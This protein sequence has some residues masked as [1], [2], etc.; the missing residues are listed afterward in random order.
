MTGRV[1]LQGLADF[2]TSLISRLNTLLAELGE[3]LD[4]AA[5]VL[6]RQDGEHA[7]QVIADAFVTGTGILTLR[8]DSRGVA[9][10]DPAGVTLSFTLTTTEV[11]VAGRDLR[12]GD[13]LAGGQVSDGAGLEVYKVLTPENPDDE[14]LTLLLADG[15]P[16]IIDPGRLFRVRR[17]AL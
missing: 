11:E 17:L 4:T 1:D 6:T 13:R 10:R 12:P 7:A 16:F 5:P 9:R 2:G 8:P 3:R 15:R 14:T